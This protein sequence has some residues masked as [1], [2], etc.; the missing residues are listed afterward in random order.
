MIE[1]AYDA[2]ARR[3]VSADQVPMANALFVRD[4]EQVASRVSQ[5]RPI[6]VLGVK[7]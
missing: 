5:A 2:F 4:P 3:L 7:I 1:L 6:R